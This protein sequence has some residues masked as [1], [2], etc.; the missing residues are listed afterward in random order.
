[1]VELRFSSV[2]T[3]KC[4]VSVGVAGYFWPASKGGIIEQNITHTVFHN[5]DLYS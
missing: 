1:M 4:V 2:E 3:V 5:S